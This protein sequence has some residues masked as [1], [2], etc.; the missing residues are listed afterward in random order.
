MTVD[1]PFK[2]GVAGGALILVGAITALRFCGSL[3]L[4]PKPPAPRA[5]SGTAAQLLT[6]STSTP[7][8]WKTYLERDAASAGLRAPSAEE[9]SRKLAYRVDEIRHVL[10]P[11]E[12]PVEL[13]G[14]RLAV[15]RRDDLV[16]LSAENT[17]DSAVAYEVTTERSPGDYVCNGAAVIP[18]NAIVIAKGEREVRT[19]CVWREGMS[20]AVTKVET[21][22]LH[23][24]SVVYLTQIPP[25]LLGLD[26]R[27]VRGHKVLP[28]KEPCTAATSQA[29]RAGVERGEI[30][31]R[32]LI[33]FYARHR[34]Q[35]Y[36]FPASYR[37]FKS[38]GERPLPALGPTQ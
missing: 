33:D 13:A 35:T 28:S 17:L 24:L 3:D 20:I 19:E 12:P 9:L 29:V 14:L 18:F 2:L 11:G 21:V 16:T 15:E 37:A 22:E 25:A 27:I 6:E 5:P 7:A 10:H 23:P 8:M 38:D 34:C 32:D 31:W 4:P 26:T 30:T 36:Q 1:T